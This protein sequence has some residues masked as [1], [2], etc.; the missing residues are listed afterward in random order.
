MRTALRK[1][2]NSTGIILPRAVLREIGLELGASMELQ[3]EGGRIV[4]TPIMDPVR[5]NWA[6]AAAEIATRADPEE[7]AWQGFGN[8]QDAEL[9][10]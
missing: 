9:T 3:V 10:W 4:A 8:E 6:A 7:G 1:M 5:K 2:G